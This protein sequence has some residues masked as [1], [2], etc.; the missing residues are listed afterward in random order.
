MII[1]K[2]TST[3]MRTADALKVMEAVNPIFTKQIAARLVKRGT[4]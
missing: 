3:T 2:T 4:K 1:A